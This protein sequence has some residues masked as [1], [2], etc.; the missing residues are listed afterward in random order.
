MLFRGPCTALRR[1]ARRAAPKRSS[2][3]LSVWQRWKDTLETR[4]SRSKAVP[5]HRVA[6]AK[7]R[8]NPLCRAAMDRF[9]SLAMT[10]ISGSRALRVLRA[11]R[12][13]TLIF[14]TRP[15]FWPSDATTRRQCQIEPK[16]PEMDILLDNTRPNRTKYAMRDQSN[17]LDFFP[18]AGQRRPVMVNRPEE[19]IL[20]SGESIPTSHYRSPVFPLYL[21][22]EQVPPRLHPGAPALAR[23]A[24][25]LGRSFCRTRRLS[26]RAR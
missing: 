3:P 19:R 4:R 2:P 9:A 8:N 7:R 26:P 21:T 10:A 24:L 14:S 12:G 23:P 15:P 5:R 16:Y 13:S 25:R 6:I 11:L 17:Y 20:L 22:G 18:P 1:I